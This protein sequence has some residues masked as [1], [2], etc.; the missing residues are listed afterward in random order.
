[1]AQLENGNLHNFIYCLEHCA[2]NDFEL[3]SI[4]LFEFTSDKINFDVA[5]YSISCPS[6]YLVRKLHRLIHFKEVMSLEMTMEFTD[7]Q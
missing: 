3:I 5:V 2:K 6:C 1:M 4:M 7:F